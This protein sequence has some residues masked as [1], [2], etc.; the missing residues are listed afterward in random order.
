MPQRDWRP[1]RAIKPYNARCAICGTPGELT[2]KM[3]RGLCSSCYARE[4]RKVRDIPGYRLPPLQEYRYRRNVHIPELRRA[5]YRRRYK[6]KTP[7]N[8]V[9]RGHTPDFHARQRKERRRQLAAERAARLAAAPPLRLEPGGLP[10]P[11]MPDNR[12]I[13]ASGGF[14]KLT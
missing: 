7:V 9:D 13:W 1:W 6:S 10:L 3:R 8:W 4:W 14:A 2:T 5:Y 12:R 11:V